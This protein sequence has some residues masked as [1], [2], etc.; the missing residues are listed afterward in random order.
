MNLSLSKMLL[1]SYFIATA[2]ALRSAGCLYVWEGRKTVGRVCGSVGILR[3]ECIHTY[4][5]LL[6]HVTNNEPNKTQIKLGQECIC[7][8]FGYSQHR[9]A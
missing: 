6:A 8:G 2:N 7:S 4:T 9:D 3:R 1:L 5:G